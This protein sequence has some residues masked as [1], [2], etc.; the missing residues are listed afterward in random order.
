MADVNA[1]SE[2][3]R[4]TIHDWADANDLD[5]TVEGAHELPRAVQEEFAAFAERLRENTNLDTRI[6]EAFDEAASGMA[7]IADSLHEQTT[8]GVQQS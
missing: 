6:A 2:E 7:G 3:I 4:N 8:F 1:V 5:T